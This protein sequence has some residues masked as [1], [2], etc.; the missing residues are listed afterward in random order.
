MAS[1]KKT[2]LNIFK[3]VNTVYKEKGGILREFFSSK[4]LSE[5]FNYTVL[6]L[7]ATKKKLLIEEILKK[8]RA[9][10]GMPYPDKIALFLKRPMVSSNK[11]LKDELTNYLKRNFKGEYS[12]VR[13]Q[14]YENKD[15]ATFAS[16]YNHT[17]RKKKKS[18]AAI[19]ANAARANGERANAERIR[20]AVANSMRAD[21]AR[22]VNVSRA[23]A[24]RANSARANSARANAARANATR[25][26]AARANA[27]PV[28]RF[29]Q[30]VRS[31][32]SPTSIP[33]TYS[34]RMALVRGNKAG[35][36]LVTDLE[37]AEADLDQ[38]KYDDE[39]LS[40]LRR[41]VEKMKDK[42]KK[43]LSTRKRS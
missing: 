27:A 11:E 43:H 9:R 29:Q 37:S 34:E 13:A 26:N 19:A 2:P 14:G 22:A 8:F 16:Q 25:A 18:S 39:P 7:S 38:A 35:S 28:S 21:I 40:P 12:A 15:Y 3:H 4:T 23:Y 17:F 20:A 32:G 31:R 42:L 1:L 36:D 5:L 24:A 30:L 6:E 10:D 33:K 41:H